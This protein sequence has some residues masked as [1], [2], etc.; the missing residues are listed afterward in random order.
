MLKV[1]ILLDGV[2]RHC[3]SNIQRYESKHECLKWG[4]KRS[5][6]TGERKKE[7]PALTLGS[8]Q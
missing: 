2:F 1:S 6:G 4:R 5:T 7:G 3:W 8:F